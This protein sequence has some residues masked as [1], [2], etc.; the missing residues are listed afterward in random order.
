MTHTLQL[1]ADLNKKRAEYIESG[2][3]DDVL[4][5]DTSSAVGM[6]PSSEWTSSFRPSSDR[7]QLF[8]SPSHSLPILA[9]A[10]L[11]P[12]RFAFLADSQGP[13][14]LPEDMRKKDELC[15][16][17]KLGMKALQDIAYTENVRD[18]TSDQRAI[19][20]TPRARK[21]PRARKMPSPRR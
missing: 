5:N 4:Y 20:R 9:M 14:K 15:N 16:R 8:L 11:F 1:E 21:I 2:R 18:L 6:P 12:N 19:V 10:Q 7:R 17:T 13:Y 3:F